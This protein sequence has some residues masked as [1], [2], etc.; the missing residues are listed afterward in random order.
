MNTQHRLRPVLAACTFF[1]LSA[2]HAGQVLTVAVFP[3]LDEAVK[4][5]LPAWQKLHPDVRINLAT[6]GYADHHNRL[7]TQLA[8]KSGVPDLVGI[9]ANYLGRFK[10][11]G[12][13]TDLT[14]PPYLAARLRPLFVHYAFEQATTGKA[15]YAL[16]ADIGPGTLFY[17]KDVLDRAGLREADLTTSWE[18]MLA[19]GRKLKAATGQYLL[20][21]A[22]D[23]KNLYLRANTAE[24]EGIYFDHN[25]R[26]AVTSA[27]FIKAFE[28]A[29]TVRKE[30]LD[31]RV[32]PW[33]NE[34]TAMLRSGKV[35]TVPSG[36]WF[37]GQLE[38]WAA[39]NTGGQWRAAPL[40]AQRNAAWGGSFYAIPAQAANKQLAWEFM[41][42]L[43]ADS[44]IQLAAWQAPALQAF[45]A[46]NSAM[47]DAYVDAPMPFFG[48]Q[49]AR[50][51][52]RNAAQATPAT[53][54]DR[55]DPLAE[56][57]VNA[58]LDAVLFNDKDIRAALADAQKQIELRLRQ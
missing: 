9:E 33:T 46:L 11:A 40:P 4:L 18:G 54:L 44:K 52:W 55:N 5:A 3:K 45:P 24:G 16:P 34:W 35:A 22:H 23:M 1:L 10:A 50:K 51:L 20:A 8:G 58:A 56:E 19:A 21:N 15:I 2:V 25:G 31:A 39:P 47:Q 57:Q 37:A 38:S 29:R 7:V 6:L 30:G 28:L 27:R 42:L 49:P 13:L 48:G 43:S 32:T 17:R 12:V 36:S 41:Q 26:P 53:R 14:A